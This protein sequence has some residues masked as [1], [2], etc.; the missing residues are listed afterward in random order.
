[1]LYYVENGTMLYQE[2][3][4]GEIV[5]ITSDMF[6]KLN[7]ELFLKLED[8]EEVQSQLFSED[9]MNTIRFDNKLFTSVTFE[10]DRRLIH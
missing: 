8:Y 5:E 1:M 3:E 9:L 10:L 2:Y 6:D 4:D 7:E